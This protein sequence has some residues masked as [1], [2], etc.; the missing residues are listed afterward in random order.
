MQ[1]YTD[2]MCDAELEA[3]IISVMEDHSFIITPATG[4]GTAGGGGGG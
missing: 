4:A 2:T 3:N 1:D